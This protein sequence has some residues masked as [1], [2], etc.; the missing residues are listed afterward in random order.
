MNKLGHL[1]A[2]GLLARDLPR[3]HRFCLKLGSL[4]PDLLV[5]TYVGGHTWDSTRDKTA[6]RMLRLEETGR[7]SC[8]SY[9]RL[10]YILHYVEDYFTY[11]HNSWYPG[12]LAEHGIYELSL[13]AYARRQ[14]AADADDIQPLRSAQALMDRLAEA[15]GEY[16]QQTPGVENDFAYL[17]SAAGQ[18]SDYYVQVFRR[19]ETEHTLVLHPAEKP[20]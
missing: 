9:L 13:T 7:E 3:R 14:G 4:L 15:H 19:H 2:T 16:A 12:T 1:T 17:M 10:G 5:F 6:R 20:N 11:P 18:V 8:L